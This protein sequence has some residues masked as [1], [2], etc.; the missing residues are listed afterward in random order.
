VLS[1]SL[2]LALARSLLESGERRLRALVEG[3]DPD[4]LPEAVWGA[5]DA[6]GAWRQDV[7][8]PDDLPGRTR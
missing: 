6:N 4:G 3:M 5:A 7:D 2:A 8:L 1:V